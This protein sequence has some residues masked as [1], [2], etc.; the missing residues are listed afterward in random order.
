ML[1]VAGLVS[2]CDLELVAGKESADRELRWVHIS[3]LEDPT[4][5]QRDEAATVR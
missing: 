2:D 3:E 4:P 1:T 5:W